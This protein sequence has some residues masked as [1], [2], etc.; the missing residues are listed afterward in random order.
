MAGQKEGKGAN[1]RKAKKDSMKTNIQ[2]GDIV[3]ILNITAYQIWELG[4][5]SCLGQKYVVK[6]VYKDGNPMFYIHSSRTNYLERVSFHPDQCLLYHRPLKN[7]LKSVVL[8]VLRIFWLG[9]TFRSKGK[10]RK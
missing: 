5:N 3:E 1:K 2:Q 9:I 10:F 6:Q 7:I 8:G 4:D